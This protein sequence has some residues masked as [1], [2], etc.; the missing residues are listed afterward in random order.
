[1]T[2][3][4][5][6]LYSPDLT[7]QVTFFFPPDEKSSKENFADVEEVKPKMAEELKGIKN[8]RSGKC[9]NRCI[10]SNGEYFE[11]D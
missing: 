11:G 10:T 5:H 8:L 9:L 6:S 7:P 2:P 3:V 4:P 1:M